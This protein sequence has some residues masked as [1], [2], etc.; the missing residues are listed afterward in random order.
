MQNKI[1]AGNLDRTIEI[2]R[3]T[4]GAKNSFGEAAETWATYF[5]CRAMRQDM[6]DAEKVQSDRPQSS[7][8]SR[9]LVRSSSETRS[10]TNADRLVHDGMTWQIEGVKQSSQGGR[11][12]FLEIT[13]IAEN[14]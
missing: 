9:F 8:M 11:D 14:A 12:R 13:A 6:R 7:L 10:V 5:T 3:K 2:E 4:A 1:S